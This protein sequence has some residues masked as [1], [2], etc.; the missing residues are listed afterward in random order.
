MKIAQKVLQDLQIYEGDNEWD[1]VILH[2]D[3]DFEATEETDSNDMSDIA[4]FTDG[5]SI[6]WDEVEKEWK[7]GMLI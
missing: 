3:L 2:Y 5:S 4:I 7:G 6:I 1:E